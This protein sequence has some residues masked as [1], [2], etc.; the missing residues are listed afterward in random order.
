MKSIKILS[1]KIGG[2][3]RVPPSKSDSHRAL[4]SASLCRADSTVSNLIF[5]EDIKATI[6][7]LRAFGVE[8]DEQEDSVSIKPKPLVAPQTEV[9]CNESGSTLRFMIPMSLLVDGKT[10]FTGR[11]RL[12]ERPIDDFLHIFDAKQV[13]YRYDGKLPLTVVGKAIDGSVSLSGNVSSQYYSGLFF[14]L[15]LMEHDTEVIVEGELESKGYVDM[16]LNTLKK[17]NIEVINEDYKRFIIKGNQEYET[18]D[19]V[20]E[21]DYS[22]A[23][24]WIVAGQISDEI[25]L[26]GLHKE[27]LQRDSQVIDVINEMKGGLNWEGDM[28]ISTPT[29]T[30]GTTIDASEIPDII[31]ILC[32]LASVSEGQTRVINGQRLRIKESDRIKSTVS[33]LSKL[34]ADIIETEDGMIING[35]SKL[36]GGSVSSWND[37]RIAMAMAIASTV[38]EQPV[39]IDG[40]EAVKKSYPHFYDDFARLGGDCR[41]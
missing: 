32:V 24:F 40:A 28:L 19:Y 25:R 10:T 27:S 23:A 9:D 29:R 39:I 3:L 30:H 37:H 21:G 16:T 7:A 17:H 11:N 8:L 38:C 22:N 13:E 26:K 4:I 2:D 1:K 34:G 15:P 35:V 18:T 33:E 31:P 14:I 20:V 6:N 41:E 5:S 12:V 36:K